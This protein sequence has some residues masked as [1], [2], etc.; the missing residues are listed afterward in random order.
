MCDQ[1]NE[2]MNSVAVCRTALAKLGVFDIVCLG[3]VQQDRVWGIK[4]L[5]YTLRN[6][7]TL[8]FILYPGPYT[9]G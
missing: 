7:E 6:R 2:E 1:I 4:V 8:D 9:D 5:I 3:F